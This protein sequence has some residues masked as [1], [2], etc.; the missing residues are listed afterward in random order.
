MIFGAT[1]FD[2]VLDSTHWH[3]FESTD[4]NFVYRVCSYL[5]AIGLLTAFLPDVERRP[6]KTR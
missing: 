3:I 1:F 6:A 4:I 2:H 5:P